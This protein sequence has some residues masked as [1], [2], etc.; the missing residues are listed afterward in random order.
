MAN[1]HVGKDQTTE[2]PDQVHLR[3]MRASW[4]AIEV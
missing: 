2:P 1:G 3:C 4:K